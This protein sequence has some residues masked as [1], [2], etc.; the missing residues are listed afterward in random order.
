MSFPTLLVRP[1]EKNPKFLRQSNQ[2]VERNLINAEGRKMLAKML[3]TMVAEVK[4]IYALDEK[5]AELTKSGI[6]FEKLKLAH[7][8]SRDVMEDRYSLAELGRQVQEKKL[9]VQRNYYECDHLRKS[10]QTTNA[11]VRRERESN[12]KR[13]N[14]TKT[15]TETLIAKSASIL[16]LLENSTDVC[17]LRTM[18]EEKR[19]L[20]EEVDELRDEK[21]AL[22]D[23]IHTKKATL[24]AESKKPF[25]KMVIECAKHYA[26][27]ET[28]T[29]KLIKSKKNLQLLKE[30]EES[31]RACGSLDETMQF[32]RSFV[33]ASMDKDTTAENTSRNAAAHNESVQKSSSRSTSFNESIQQNQTM[34][35]E[36]EQ[37][38]SHHS[39]NS[40]D[41]STE[42]PPV[43][44][45]TTPT[46][47]VVPKPT[48]AVSKVAPVVAKP[49]PVVAKPTPVVT[50]PAP[51]TAKPAPVVTKSYSVATKPAPVAANPPEATPKRRESMVETQ[52]VIP[53]EP[54]PEPEEEPEEE[55][56][57]RSVDVMDQGEDQE[58]DVEP[59]ETEEQPD[60]V[61]PPSPAP[62]EN[63]DIK[64]SAPEVL[65]ISHQEDSQN[66]VE[67]RIDD[68]EVLSE[69][70]SSRSASF[71]FNFFGNTKGGA[72]E[73]VANDTD[74]N[75]DFNFGGGDDVST[76]GSGGAFDFL[77][78]GGGDEGQSNNNDADPFGFGANT[79]GTGGGDMSFNFNFDGDNEGGTSSGAGGNSTSFFNF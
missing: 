50:K 61:I 69:N 43:P 41:G 71:N 35:V 74:G 42:M 2:L 73:V 79:G 58:E 14:K 40:R 65:D 22:A 13:L 39:E 8:T 9:D 33:L 57:N 72:G 28:L 45:E 3:A 6:L 78:C 1:N 52:R 17:K 60:V 44:V 21:K 38:A 15:S 67:M 63:V 64:P 30:E 46:P 59:M 26:L 20:L 68:D 18:E 31:R 70:G 48:P 34:E 5:R 47:V 62:H 29:P 16:K 11:E 53:R 32:D 66:D 12:E 51:I 75:F 23:D 77:N 10:V 55:D 76:N 19:I 54:S 27:C 25:K 4:G 7:Q 36:E 24:K 37:D 49:A 56:A